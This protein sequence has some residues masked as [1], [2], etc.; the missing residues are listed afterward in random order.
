MVSWKTLLLT[1]TVAFGLG[2]GPAHAAEEAKADDTQQEASAGSEE[3]ALLPEPE[4]G[5]DG[6]HKHP[7]FLNSFLFLP[8]DHAQAAE[9]GKRFVIF[10][11]QKGCPYCEKMHT[12]NMREPEVTEYIKDNFEVLQLNMWGDRMVTD[13]DGTEISEKKLAQKYRVN[14]TPTIMFFAEDPETDA[15]EVEVFRLPGYFR[16]FHFRNAFQYVREKRYA[17]DQSFQR[18]ILERVAEEQAQGNETPSR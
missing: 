7:W 8:E 14:F 17:D 4:L 3:A 6:L 12:V 13:F 10:W 2:L 11:E 9:N 18:F 15:E 1:A 16:P 5:D